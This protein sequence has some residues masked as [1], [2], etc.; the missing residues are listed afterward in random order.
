MNHRNTSEEQHPDLILFGIQGSGK[1]T[2]G[3]HLVQAHGYQPFITG[4]AL[5]IISET[6]TDVG[7]LVKPYV[8]RGEH[9]PDEIAMQ[10]VGQ[11]VAGMNLNSPILFDGMPRNERQREL[12]EA[13]LSDLN[14]TAVAIHLLLSD[15]KARERMRAR[16]RPDDL[17]PKTVDTRIQTFKN[18][19]LPMIEGFRS[20]GKLIEIDAEL[21]PT[22]VYKQIEAALGFVR[23]QVHTRV[24]VL[25]RLKD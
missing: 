15:D 14:R 2:Q 16:G 24:P 3:A 5:R 18:K 13:I 22:E 7:R 12:H 23:K 17:N 1:G 8:E 6:D 25:A 9:A 19:T 20:T 11:A 10:A 4:D 21:S